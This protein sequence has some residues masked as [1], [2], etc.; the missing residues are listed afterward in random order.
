MARKDE[1]SFKEQ[2]VIR[3]KLKKRSIHGFMSFA[4]FFI[5]TQ[6]HICKRSLSTPLKDV[7]ENTPIMKH[8][9]YNKLL[10]DC[11]NNY[12][13]DIE[14]YCDVDKDIYSDDEVIV[15]SDSKRY[16]IYIQNLNYMFGYRQHS[17]TY[18]YKVM[19]YNYPRHHLLSNLQL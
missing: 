12:P 9:G 10:L 14:Y 19:N 18:F 7:L 4:D 17:P 15:D 3:A 11:S 2:S 6:E 1:I 13:S 16:K 5:K 8:A